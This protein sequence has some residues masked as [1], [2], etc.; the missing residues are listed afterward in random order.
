M[1]KRKKKVRSFVPRREISQQKRHEDVIILWLN[2][3][4]IL[5]LKSIEYAGGKVNSC[6][7]FKSSLPSFRLSCLTV[8]RCNFLFS[9]S[10]TSHTILKLRAH[11]SSSLRFTADMMDKVT[12]KNM[13]LFKKELDSWWIFDVFSFSCFMKCELPLVYDYSLSYSKIFRIF[14]H[15]H[16]SIRFIWIILCQILYVHFSKEPKKPKRKFTKKEWKWSLSTI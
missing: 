3:N 5:K 12:S 13:N 6:S 9:S 4:F 11:F 16:D 1:E 8:C 10:F 14:F 15:F 2:S 7:C